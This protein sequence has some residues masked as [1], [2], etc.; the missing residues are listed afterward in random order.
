MKLNNKQL[1]RNRCSIALA[2]LLA[3]AAGA[4]AQSSDAIIDKL[5]EKGILTV[6][7]AN[8]LREEADK[9]FTQAYS[10]KNGMPEWVSAFKF[11]GD[12]RARYEGF[13][14]DAGFI[15]AG[16]TNQF[17]DRSRFRYR[18]RLGATVSMFDNLEAGLRLTSDD[19]ATGGSNNEGD[20]ISGNTTM[21][22]NGSKKL[23][24]V[25]QAYGR[26]YALNGPE[27]TGILTVGKM[28]NPLTI[29]DMVFDPDYTPEGAAIQLG[30]RLSDHHGFK[31]N[32]GGFVLDEFSGSSN[33]PYLLAAQVRWD[34]VWNTKWSSALGLT[35]ISIESA[36]RLT[37][38]VVPNI[39]R[40]N[41][42]DVNGALVYAYNPVIVDGSV[43]YTASSFPFYKGAFPIKVGGEYMNNPAAPSSVTDNYAWNAGIMLGKSGKKGTWDLS[44]NYKWLGA[45]AMWEELV[46]SDFGAFYASPNSPANSG[47]GIGYGAGTNV[48]GHIVR[49]AYSPSDSVTL[50]VKWFLT[51]LINS[52]PSDPSNTSSKMN[53][54]Q[55]D[56]SWKF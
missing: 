27:W 41:T 37:N 31:L 1:N 3:S 18:L 43:T 24:Y 15:N 5:V 32:L 14:S 48:K 35:G 9:N 49:F 51:E 53:R 33:D 25:D 54:L 6:K 34:A 23:I 16:R 21:Q 29:D 12:F 28:E 36:S 20:P 7:E 4:R 55:V 42:R 52:F 46:D 13:Y 8:D 22:N 45:D 26:W 47:A 10:V 40:G 11:N 39:N 30:Y 17:L 50:S 56:A 38:S 19:V 44:Y 2:V